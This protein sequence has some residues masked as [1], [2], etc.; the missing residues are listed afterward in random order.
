VKVTPATLCSVK[1]RRPQHKKSFSGSLV[2]LEANEVWLEC[3]KE[4]KFEWLGN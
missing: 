3:A 1:P 4:F 2:A